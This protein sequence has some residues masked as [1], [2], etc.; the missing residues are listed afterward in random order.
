MDRDPKVKGKQ[1]VKK[2]RQEEDI[3]EFAFGDRPDRIGDSIHS[4]RKC[5]AKLPKAAGGRGILLLDQFTSQI[6]STSYTAYT[7]ASGSRWRQGS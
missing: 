7:G 2:E 6:K 4:R 1:Q 3:Y 5:E